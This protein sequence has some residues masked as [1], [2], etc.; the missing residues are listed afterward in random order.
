MNRWTKAHTAVMVV[1]VLMATMINWVVAG[2]MQ[3][4]TITVHGTS[5]LVAGEYYPATIKSWAVDQTNT[6]GQYLSVRTNGQNYVYWCLVAG[7]SDSTNIYTWS[8]TTDVVDNDTTWR[9]I[10]ADRKKIVLCNDSTNVMYLGIGATAVTNRG[11][12]LNANGG[13]ITFD[14]EM[15]DAINA[16]AKGT[17]SY[18]TI[19][20]L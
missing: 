11:I 15:R 2:G 9:P 12:R 7:T 1:T 17:N 19:Q 16:V 13:T 20:Q 8:S 14:V 4:E 18:L 10:K 5:I 6:V 3:P